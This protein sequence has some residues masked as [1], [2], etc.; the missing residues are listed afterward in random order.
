MALAEIA[1]VVLFT[2]Y[3]SA[4]A[5]MLGVVSDYVLAEGN[6]LI[7]ECILSKA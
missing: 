1:R 2:F 7:A 6:L 3:I 4:K 5:P